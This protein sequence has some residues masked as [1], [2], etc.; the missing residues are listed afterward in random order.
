M[1]LRQRLYPLMGSLLG[2]LTFSHYTIFTLLPDNH[3]R[4]VSWFWILMVEIGFAYG[5][6]WAIWQIW[7]Q[8]QKSTEKGL[9]WLGGGLDWVVLG[10]ILTLGLSLTFA[11]YPLTAYWYTLPT[12]AYLGMLYGVYSFCSN[13]E[14]KPNQQRILTLLGGLSITFAVA[15]LSLW[16]KQ[17]VLPELQRLKTLND[18]GIEASFNFS[19]LFLRNWATFGHPNYVAGFLL[20]ALPLLATLTL[21]RKSWQRPLWGIG[22]GIGL[23]DFYTTNSRGGWLGLLVAIGMVA[24]IL[25]WRSDIP[26]RWVG[27]GT[28][29]AITALGVWAMQNNRLRRTFTG[30]LT[31]SQTGG[32]FS[33]R[34]ITAYTG[35]QMGWSQPITGLGLGSVPT[36]Y[37]K[38][39]PHWAGQEAEILFQLHSTP[40]QIWAELGLLGIIGLVLGW[41]LLFKMFLQVL[42]SP[43]VSW[44]DRALV[45]AIASGLAGYTIMA[46]T[47]YQLDVIAIT[48]LLVIEIALT[49]AIRAR[50]IQPSVYLKSSWQPV[51]LG[52]ISV[53]II[54]S[55]LWLVPVNLAW[56]SSAQA[57]N[58]VRSLQPDTKAFVAKLTQAQQLAPWEPYYPYQLGW[59][60]GDIALANPNPQ[61]Q[62]P[63]VESGEIWFR[64][65]MK[66]SPYSEFGHSN[67]GWLL[68]N[69]DPNAA[70]EEFQQSAEL[71]PARRTVMFALGQGWFAVGDEAKG[72]KAMALEF[73]RYPATW[74]SPIGQESA[75][76]PYYPRILAE[77]NAIYTE[78][79]ENTNPNNTNLQR[80][81][82]QSRG[83][84]A[85]WRGDIEAAKQ[86]F[87]AANSEIGQLLIAL[88][89]ITPENWQSRLTPTQQTFLETSVKNNQPWA[90]T[91]QAWLQ[92][93]QRE[94]L[95]TK[96]WL[97]AG[98]NLN[99]EIIN[100][101]VNSMN[102]SDT[103][104]RWLQ[105]NAPSQT[106][107]IQRTGF[108]VIHR[109]LDG[110]T[111]EDL[112]ILVE[113]LPMNYLFST[114]LQDLH[115]EPSLDQKLRQAR[116]L[117]EASR[118][119]IMF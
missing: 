25:L 41:I 56:L 57:F 58:E 80:W 46:I 63:L 54:G 78:L 86:D 67:L 74:T 31:L 106:F 84:L 2:L 73:V 16:T 77:T 95:L 51:A 13:F 113:N 88:D 34:W 65:A 107:R 94:T 39:R 102:N 45:G 44:E 119:S 71:V 20:L 11:P 3:S 18:N 40:V 27:F 8:P 5:V 43:G 35:W 97:V 104:R 82:Y 111:P 105:E 4:M 60:L 116:Y 62:K 112:T 17:T 28:I 10:I 21:T 100:A 98:Q 14:G 9:R 66:Y 33:Y 26:R 101:L 99:P 50:Y 38:F 114:L 90:L 52:M 1:P 70:L 103:F 22:L 15:S 96:G 108:N 53:T 93:A 59:Y 69:D 6:L 7:V 30:I 117:P 32:E 110:F 118:S 12:L 23:V 85:W 72:I 47:D 36:F 89:N 37:Q 115:Y 109:H 24:A 83:M 81:L 79:I 55:L 19:N 64:E 29:T 92:P 76:Q 91:I 87:R 49:A 75:W 68:L 48:G 61:V 42:A